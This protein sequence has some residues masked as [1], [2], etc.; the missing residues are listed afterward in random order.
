MT[1]FI[2]E[3]VWSD[4]FATTDPDL[5]ES[6]HLASWPAMSPAVVAPEL[7]EQVAVVRRLVELGRA[8]RSTSKIKTRQ[9]LRRAL[10]AAPLWAGLP[11]DLQ[12]EVL[13]E[14]NVL[15]IE[16]L[17]S[18]QDD[19]VDV[20]AKANFRELGKRFGKATPLVAKAIAAADARELHGAFRRGEQ[21]TVLVA[22]E[23]TPVLI[24]DVIITEVPRQGWAVTAD[25]GEMLALDLTLDDELRSLGLARDIVREIQE[26][27]KQAGL[28]VTD[29]ITVQWAAQGATA[30]A[31]T[32]HGPAI[33]AEVLAVE[34][35]PVDDLARGDVHA[36]DDLGLKYTLAKV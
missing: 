16:K 20:S 28:E 18:D 24:G 25:A 29:R 5:A 36:S 19:L 12:Q 32:T 3:R 14:I 30:E 1:P 8:A 4:L 33:A 10:V 15:S 6:V 9:P 22:G 26:A 11:T 13:D 34:F 21:P 31:L 35:T 17:D 23:A 27:R 2:T 7:G